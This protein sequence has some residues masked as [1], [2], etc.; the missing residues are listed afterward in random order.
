MRL[1]LRAL[2]AYL[3]NVLDPADANDFSTKVQESAVASG[4][5]QR[6]GAITK[7][8]RMN[9]PRIDACGAGYKGRR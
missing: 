2:L 4:L 8:M 1:T 7:K 6:I 9:A 5:V 3:Y